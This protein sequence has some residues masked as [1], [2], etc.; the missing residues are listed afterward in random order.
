[1]IDTIIFGKEIK[2]LNLLNNP[3]YHYV[4]NKESFISKEDIITLRQTIKQ[5]IIKYKDHFIQNI[6]YITEPV[7]TLYEKQEENIVKL[8]GRRDKQEP[9]SGVII[10]KQFIKAYKKHITVSSYYYLDINNNNEFFYLSFINNEFFS[11]IWFDKE[12]GKLIYT[13]PTF[14][15]GIGAHLSKEEITKQIIAGMDIARELLWFINHMTIESQILGPRVKLHEQNCKYEN[16][17]NHS[18]EIIKSNYL[19]DLH[20][21]GAFK[22][23]G[24]F[25]WQPYKINGIETKKLIFISDFVKTGYTSKLRII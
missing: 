5:N 4:I 1:M 21:S 10:Y 25:R 12:K 15:F 23:S 19:Y 18:I 16:H 14:T 17:T 11:S 20:K 2:S 13:Q 7:Y 8:M 6:K 9:S 24:H 22:V 3:D